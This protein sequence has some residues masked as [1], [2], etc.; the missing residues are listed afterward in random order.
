MKASYF[1]G[2][3]LRFT[4]HGLR[5]KVT[6]SIVLPLFLILGSFTVIEY[7]HRQNSLL[8][9][10]SLLAAY[11]GQVIESSL[12]QA[13]LDDNFDEVQVLLDTIDS[14]GQFNV[15]YLMDTNGKVIFA[16]NGEGQGVRLTNQSPDCA[17]CHALSADERQSSVVVTNQ[18]GERIFRS[19]RPIENRPACTQCHD[20][21]KRLLGLLLTDIPVEPM[22]SALIADLQDDLVWWVGTIIV[23]VII[24][25]LVLNRLV[26]KRL[27]ELTKAIAGL[28]EGRSHKI[29]VANPTDEIGQLSSSFNLMARKIESREKE[30]SELSESLHIQSARR[31]ELLKRLITAQESERK[32]VARELHDELGQSLSGLALRTQALERLICKDIDL[33]QEQ[34]H[35]MRILIEETTDHMYDL[36]MDLRPS[37]LDDMGLAVALRLYA[38]RLFSETAITYTQDTRGLDR[39]L[40]SVIETTCYRIFQEALNNVLRHSQANHVAITLTIHDNIFEGSIVDDGQGFDLADVPMDDSSPRGIGLMGML[41]RVTQCNGDLSIDSKKGQGTKIA[42]NIPLVEDGDSV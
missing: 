1:Q 37:V 38:E 5:A 20:K 7:F 21:D 30:N 22:E 9:N 36:I 2:L 33:A 41:E 17:L 10:L 35:D 34:I 42:L 23:T 27:Y 12:R 6:L 24:V 11:S 18:D 39:R 19:M 13:M 40:P 28:G 8:D 31:G 29:I 16:P 25:N 4:P 32:R 26:L 14:S 3:K 15:I